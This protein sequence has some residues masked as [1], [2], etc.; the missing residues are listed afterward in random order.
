MKRHVLL[1]LTIMLCCFFT[2]G[3]YIIISMDGVTN[4]LEKVIS[5]HQVE[6]LRVNLENHIKAVQSD[7]LL[8]DSPHTR[9]FDTIVNHIE[10][11]EASANVCLTCHHDEKTKRKLDEMESSVHGYMKKLSRAMTLQADRQRLV[12]VRREAFA[13]GENLLDTIHSLS[14]ASAKRIAERIERIQLDVTNTKRIIV[15]LV[16]LGPLAILFITA[17]FLRRFTGSIDV[18]MTA[19]KKLEEGNLDYQIPAQLKDEFSFLA[20]SFNKMALSLKSQ[21]LQL[22]S[23]QRLYQTLFESAGDA[24]CILDTEG[25]NVGRIISANP[26]AAKLYGYSVEELQGLNTRDLT[27]DNTLKRFQER[28][29]KIFAGNWL[30]FTVDRKH[31]NGT[32]FPAELSVGLLEMDEHQYVL[33]F[34]RDITE[35]RQAEQELLR[36]NQMAIVGQMAAGLAHEIKNPLAGIKV[37][38]EVLADELELAQEDQ[39]LFARIINEINRMERLLKNLLNFARPPQP[40]FDLV[41]LNRLLDYTIKNIEVTAARTAQK[42]ISFNREFAAD[43]QQVEADSSQLQQVILNIFLN[44]IEAMQT[45]GLI[46]VMTRMEDDGRIK[47]EIVDN[48]PGMTEAT[49]E[50]VFNPF[51]TTKS[52]GT[53][54]GLAI[55]RRLIEQHQGTIDVSSQQ[56]IGTTFTIL[57]PQTQKEGELDHE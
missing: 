18:L 30:H 10:T 1:G 42:K 4:K 33:S 54:L 56:D 8:Q 14:L 3:F 23:M 27:P 29:D 55:C 11:M 50:K 43:L 26:A 48:G 31:K 13:D 9:S 49:L 53:G 2:G 37:S 47:I 25:E 34:S 17:F 6:F 21:R 32:L 12:S 46:S 19:T 52:K 44:A 39:E 41:E 22:V 5:F 24:I 40:H 15:A 7:L 20:G 38:M 36:A 57:L 16:V 45:E 28:L 35:R 51:F